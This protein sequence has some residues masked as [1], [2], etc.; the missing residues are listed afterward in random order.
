MTMK[1]SRS[2]ILM[3]VIILLIIAFSLFFKVDVNKKIQIEKAPPVQVT[4]KNPFDKKTQ[5]ENPFD[6]YHNPI[7]EL[8]F[9]QTE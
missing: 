1:I 9:V 5:Y 2:S 7:D 6:D 4:Y 3:I 8:V